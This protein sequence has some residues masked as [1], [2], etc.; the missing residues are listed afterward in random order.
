MLSVAGAWLR[1]VLSVL[2]FNEG[3]EPLQSIAQWYLTPE[4]HIIEFV[5]FNLFF[6]PLAA[7]FIRRQHTIF[8]AASPSYSLSFQR[9]D[10]LIGILSSLCFLGTILIKVTKPKPWFELIFMLQPCHL[11]NL[12]VIFMSFFKARSRNGTWC[13]N[14]Y[15]YV[16]SATV[17]AMAFPDMRDRHSLEILHFWVLHWLLVIAPFYYEYSAK[18]DFWSPCWFSGFGVFGAL[19][20]SFLYPVSALHGSNIN[21]LMNPPNVALVLGFGPYFRWYV[22]FGC[23]ILSSVCF[24]LMLGFSKYIAP[25][26][27]PSFPQLNSKNAAKSNPKTLKSK[28]N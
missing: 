27:R 1:G 11:L 20:Y 14:L 5:L 6:V 4:Q 23:F 26:I 15:L 19:H 21:Y 9:F 24:L 8:R 22:S 17:F 7:G 18:Y 3:D 13:F 28:D 16:M 25:F 10:L 12:L 2:P